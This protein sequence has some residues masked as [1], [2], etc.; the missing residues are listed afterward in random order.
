MQF[1]IVTADFTQL[2]AMQST[3][4]EPTPCFEKTMKIDSL[5][6]FEHMEFFQKIS[7]GLAV[8]DNKRLL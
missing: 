7:P 3:C 2:D 4:M 8:I 1:G 5:F 6:T